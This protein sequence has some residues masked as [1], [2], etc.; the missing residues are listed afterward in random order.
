MLPPTLTFRFTRHKD[1]D[2]P[3]RVAEAFA[4][5]VSRRGGA[6]AGA[7]HR[8]IAQLHP[9]PPPLPIHRTDGNIVARATSWPGGPGFHQALIAGAEEVAREADVEIT[10]EDSTGFHAARDRAALEAAFT[11]VLTAAARE[12]I[13]FVDKDPSA[14]VQ[15]GLPL[16]GAPGAL[17]LA[18][19]PPGVFTPDG[20]QDR[21]WLS[22][23]AD[24]ELSASAFYPWWSADPDT[25]RLARALCETRIT[26]RPAVTDE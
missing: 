13:A 17:R 8:V 1:H 11:E 15:L 22:R 16:P 24:R 10:V 25:A 2:A 18:G 20:A 12:A 3:R 26:W 21:A 6:I 9:A 4:L 5:L 19:D 7:G 23:L 14:H